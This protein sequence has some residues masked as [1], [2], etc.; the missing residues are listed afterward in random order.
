MTRISDVTIRRAT[1]ADYQRILRLQEAN[2]ITN[3]TAAETED[4]FLS[5]KF[6]EIQFKEM[7]M[8][9]GVVVADYNGEIVGYLCGASFKYGQQFQIL[10][11]II[12]M[13]GQLRINGKEL[14]PDKTFIYGP[15]CIARDFRGAGLLSRLFAALKEIAEHAYKFCILFI[16]DTNT[17]SLK[18]HIEKL[19]MTELGMFTVH[20]KSY[21]LLGAALSAD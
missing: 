4:G 8:D 21:H 14:T 13:F 9:L 10:Q 16:A 11:V 2:L 5:K 6:S 17:R 3:L 19:G 1:P 18:A 20:E 12:G 15:V 7:N